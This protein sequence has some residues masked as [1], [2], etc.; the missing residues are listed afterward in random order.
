M[1]A[2]TIITI[3]IMGTIIEYIGIKH[4]FLGSTLV[5]KVKE[6]KERNAEVR[7]MTQ[8]EYDELKAKNWIE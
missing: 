8:A 3:I 1:T 2:T 6:I 7:E 5:R 4:Y